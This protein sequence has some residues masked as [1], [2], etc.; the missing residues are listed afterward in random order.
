MRIKPQSIIYNKIK[1][2][3]KVLTGVGGFNWLEFY[4]ERQISGMWR[5]I[6]CR[7]YISPFSPH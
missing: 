3:K 6:V 7:G 1:F 4:R 2:Y 5:N